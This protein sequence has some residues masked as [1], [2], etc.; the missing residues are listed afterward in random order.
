MS[1]QKFLASLQFTAAE[2]AS[3]VR[4]AFR[5]QPDFPCEQATQYVQLESRTLY[6]AAPIAIDVVD[7]A[8]AGED[9]AEQAV[10]VGLLEA[11]DNSAQESQPVDSATMEEQQ[12]R[13]EL[14]LVDTATNDYQ[15]LVDDILAQ[16][17]A[18][19]HIEV[20]L[21][22]SA[23]DGIEQIS[24]FLKNYQDL[25][26]I[27]LVSHGSDGAVKFGS[28]WLTSDS[29]AVYV[30]DI[31]GWR[32]ALSTD[33]DM[34][35]YGCDLASTVEGRTLVD[36]LAM[37]CDCDVAASNDATGHESLGGDWELE[38]SVGVID[39]DL[40]FESDL[41]QTWLAILAPG[42][43][44]TAIWR[45]SGTNTPEFNQWDG[46]SFGSEGSAAN[47]GEWRIMQGAEAPTRD[48]AIIVG[49]DTG[50][51]IEGQMWNG[52]SWS[53]LSI[54]PLGTVSQTYWWGMDV[55]YE[56]DSGDALMVWTDG[57]NVK[58]ATWNGTAWS[59]VNTLGIYTGA[60]PRQLQLAA[61]PNNDEM[62]LVVSD[63]NSRDTA[64]VW[65]GD[66]WGNSV[67]LATS[68]AGDRTDINVAYEQQSGHA[69]V[70]YSDNNNNDLR[71]Q[72]WNGVNWSGQNT[73]TDPGASND[74]R[75]T[76][77][78]SDPNSD[79]IAVGVVTF[80]AEAWF[81]VW[82]GSAWGD[83]ILAETTTNGSTSLNVA[84]AFE[85]NSGDVL[86]AYAEGTKDDMRYR[87]WSSGGGWSAELTTPDKFGDSLNAMT[88]SSDPFSDQIML[89]LQ[90]DG[91]DLNFV[92]WNGSA[93]ESPNEQ[94]TNTGETKNQP[95]LF[96]WD[97]QDVD[98]AVLT[99]VQDT[100][101]KL[102]ETGNNF[103]VGSQLIV[104]RESTDL[105][106]ALVQFDLSSIPV[107]AIIQSA[108]LNLEATAVDGI[109]TI[110]VYQLLESWAEGTSNGSS[111]DANW[112]NRDTGTA[113]TTAGGY[114][115]ATAID[116]LTASATGQHSW[117]ITT[118][119]QD[120]V[121]GTD[122]NY[123]VMIAS[124][125][126]GGNRT[127]SFDSREGTTAPQ[128]IIHYSVP[129]LAPTDITPNT[130]SVNEHVNTVGG[131][132]VA[133]LTTTDP[134]IG[135]TFTYTIIGGA[136]AAKFS[137]GGA[138]SDELLLIDGVL[139]FEV[140]STYSV[141]VRTT[142]AAGAWYE[143][144]L[145]VSV[146]DL[147]DAPVLDNAG[148]M[149]LGSV[150][151]NTVEPSGDLVSAIIAS[152]GG[153]RITDADSGAVEGMAVT[154]VDNAQGDWQYSTNGGSS[155]TSFGSVSNA[156]AVVLTDT[157]SD[158]IRFVPTLG[159]TGSATLSFRAWDTSDAN[160]SGTTGVDTTTNGG[161]TAYSA[162]TETAGIY[163]EPT[164]VLLW[165]STTGDVGPAYSQPDS[166]VAGLP[167]WSQSSVIGMGDPNLSFG[168]G[169]T[170]GTFGLVSNFDAFAADGATILN[171]LHYVTYDIVLTGAGISGGNI[172]LLAEDILLVAG[173]ADTLTTT[174]SGAPV[175]WSNSLAVTAGNVYAFRAENSGD[176]SSGYLRLLMST[177]GVDTTQAITL[178][179]QAVT[180]GGDVVVAAG[181]F[182]F[183]QS[184]ATRENN[185]YWYDTSTNTA[186]LLIDG[187]DVGIGSP[188]IVGLEL[189]EAAS[190]VG[191][192][193][194]STGDILVTVDRTGT[195]GGNNL[196]V[197]AQDVFTLS[198]T[199]TTYGSGTAA[200]NASL[201]FDGDGSA[202]FDDNAE[203]L[204]AISLI[205]R[206]TGTNQ[207]P[208]INN[209][210]GP[211]NF[212]ENGT[213]VIVDSTINVADADS[214]DFNGGTLSVS[215][216]AGVAFGDR[217]SIFNQGTG[218]GQIGVSG[219]NVTY[220]FG[221]GAITIGTFTGGFGSGSPLVVNLNANADST[222]T[223]A[224][225]RNVTFWNTSD[226]P[227]TAARTIEF[228]LTDGDGGTSS[229]ISQ[230]A[231]VTAQ[232]DAPVAVN[233]GSGLDFDG[234]DD[235]VSIADDPSL[236]MTSTMTMEAWINPD[237][238]ANGNRMIINKEGEYEVAL[239]SNDR[240]YWAFANS[241]PGW[242]WH[243]TGYTVT[244]GEWT[245]IAVTYDNG[246][247]TTY[248][249]GQAVDS[250]SGSGLIGDT[251]P[252]LNELRIGG[253]MNNPAG[254]FFDGRIDD[255]R[256]W[257]TVR[258]QG[259]IQSNLDAVLTGGEAGLAGH[260]SFSEGT[261]ST[262]TDSTASS[263]DGTLVD[264]G[265][266]TVGPQWTGY[267]TNEDTPLNIAVGLGIVANDLD[268]DGDSLL[269]TQINGSGANVG[270][271]FTLASGAQ[272]TVNA[273][274]DFSYDPNGAFEYLTSGQRVT[275]TFTYQISDGNGGFETA[276]VTI[277]ISG[278]ND[279]PTVGTNTGTT[280]L[281]GSGA[282][283]ITSALLNEG[284]P[285]DDG[286]ELTYTVTAVSIHG[287]LTLSGFGVLGLNDTFTQAD[288]DAGNLTYDHD[289]SESVSDAFNFS[290]ADGGE[291]G[292]SAA[293]GTFNI[294]ITAVNDEQ[295]LTTNTG[296][297]VAEGSTGNV[298]TAAMLDTNDVD[299]TDA[300]LVYTVDV[301]P[302]NGTLYRNA[303]ALSATDTFTQ[304][305]IVAGLISYDHDGSQTS[306]D[307]FDFTVDDGAGTTTSSTF[308]WTITN[309]NDAPV[310]ASI[311]GAALAYTEN[312]G[313]AAITS[314]L[315]ISDVDD[316]NI[317]SAVVQ[318]TGNYAN[319]QDVLT[320]V[321][322]NGITGTWTAGTGTLSL[323]GSAT[324]AQYEAALRS[325]TYTN[326]S[327]NPS[328]L[329]RTVSVTVNDGDV[330]SQ[331]LTREITIGNV[332]D[333]PTNAGSLP[334]D[335][336]VTE[337]VSSNV[338]LSAINLS[339]VDHS[340]G[341]LTVTLSTSAGGNL[342]AASGG[343]VTVGGSGTGTLTLTGTLASLNSYL[344]TASNVQYLHSTTHLNGNDADTINVVV[345][346][347]GNTGTGGGTNQNLGTVNVDITAV[348]DEQVLATNTGATVAEGST[349][350][351][352]TAAMLDTN[353][354][355]NTDAQLVYTV[356]VAPVNG[357]LYRNAVALSATD[358][359]SQA[360]IV[361]GLISYDH[362][363]SQ[364]SNDSFDFT[365]DDG[366]GTTTSSTFNWTV[367]NTND[368]PVQSSIE[369][370]ALAYTENDG[371]VAI[372]ST[373]AISDVDDTTLESA[374]VQITGNYANGQ[375]VLAF[376]NQ[377]GI[378]GTWTAGTGTLSLS[379][380]ATLAQY[381]AALRSITY[382]NTSENP[383][384]LT[385]TVSFTVNDGDVNSNTLT[386]DITLSSVNDD[387]TNAGSLP[388]DITVTEDVSSNVDLSA[389]N[390]SDVDHSGGNLTVTLNT[391]TGGNL[392]ASS[393][394]GVTVGGSGTGTLTLTGTLASLN[395]FLDTAS[396]V[397][398]L[399]STTHLNGNDAD[400]I[401]VVVNDNGNTGTGGGTNQNLGTVNVDITAVNDEQVLATNTGA[402]VAEGS[403]GNVV[404]AAMLDT[405]DVD[406][407]DAQL[408][409]TVDVAPVNGTLYRN[410]VALSATDTFT[411]A[412][413]VAG[414]IS[415]D[416]DGS[417][418]S[419]DSF[420]FTVDDGAG[421][422]TSAT[423]TWT[424]SNTND[425]P[426]QSSIEGAALAYT[427]NDGAVA[428]TST[429]AIS[430]VDDTNLE[431]AVVQITGNYANGQ[432]VLAFV[433]QNGIT[434]TWTAGTGTLSLSG[435][436]ALAQ[437][438]A[439]LRS[440][441]YT[442]TSDNPS[443]LTRT[444]SI[445]VN[446]GD[447]NSNTLTRDIALSS[448]NDD[449]T[450][451][452]SLPSDITVTED[453][454]SNVDLS[455]INLS[456]VDH[457]GGNLTVTLSTSTGGNL[458]A[459][460]G[461]GV[462]VGGSG[463]GT[464][465]LIGTLAS[466]NTF[467][468]TPAN[469]Q[470]LHG[471]AN[472]FGNDADT[473]NVVVND[474][475]NT[476]SGGGSDQ[477]LGT[478]NVDITAVNDEQVLTTN[479]GTT[480]AEGSTGNVITAAMLD[481]NDVDNTDAQLV[482]TVDVA[483]VNGTLYRNGVALSAT[484]TF[485]Q[486]DIVAGLITYDHDGSQTSSDSFDFTV[487]DGT[488][489]TTSST[490][491]WTISNTNDAPVQS[492]IEG[493]ALAYSENDG[494]V[495]I[496]STLAIS[497]VD[498]T[499]IESAVVQITG[500]YANGQDV[501]TF[502]DQNGITGTW[503]AG[504][505]TLSLSGSA[506]LAQYEAAL[507]SITYTNTSDNPSTLTRT[508]S[509]TVNDGDV[510]S[511]TLTRDITVSSVND[512][513]T[514]AGSLPSD[515]TVT[516]D[517]SSNVD[518]SAI[519][520]SDVDHSGG[521]LTVTLSTST[522]GNLSASSGGGV[523]VGGSGTGSLTLTGT[524]ASLNTF[525]DTASNVQ[526]L[527]STANLNGNDADTI[528]VVVNDNGNTGSGG[529]TNQ[530]LGTVNVDITA[531][532][533]EQV[534]TT[535]TGATV[536]EGSTGNVVTAAM[537]DTND[538][539]NTDAQLIY[540]VD[541]APVNGTLYRN[542]VALSA[543]DTLYPGRHRGR[544]DY[545]RPRRQ[546]D[547]QRQF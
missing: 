450:N 147:N 44:G 461:G 485:T 307:S 310:Q 511:N 91:S 424:I 111:D 271:Q 321:D 228:V 398:Y 386:R 89:A 315:A 496:T 514:N 279:V 242:A 85:S 219:N 163:V 360:D 314:T 395:T 493:A 480:V 188:A 31:V 355:D 422:T 332:N 66:A 113:W 172:N 8:D 369:G 368:A 305:D 331:H 526:Y 375:D 245:H 23:Q 438:E 458:S 237:A 378:T 309:V 293:T 349:G 522:G 544:A 367:S 21:L 513:P 139:D 328:T 319:G 412:D 356:D 286:S 208:V 158:K 9:L 51:T 252:V 129:N 97:Q 405:N 269:V 538:V 189:V 177:P 531:V 64:Y 313:A 78:A 483:P 258:T 517:V 209:S 344:D 108:T 505:G 264:G 17:S 132:S 317:E 265:A 67:T 251:Y 291:D 441:T 83:Q 411:Q 214:T 125:D 465:T 327:E 278:V 25:D 152:A 27:H 220:N 463:T 106:R 149:Q 297:T 419:S 512:D 240:I 137:I 179:E 10:A 30:S 176:Y 343:G 515:I 4:C 14:V 504:T 353:D 324:L 213:P 329:T 468:D 543:T 527:H 482:Y 540:T 335:I 154:A 190:T 525:L 408:V 35:I 82:D 232:P 88:L 509:F 143:E 261:G 489:T 52:T 101:I 181:D 80:N 68:T 267:V 443:T 500:N 192:V 164:E 402:T 373:L 276:A 249:N 503:T 374:V 365:V 436:A 488:G 256:I 301:A 404:T 341:N 201:L 425:A 363:G 45:E 48:E 140:K 196:S 403:T 308:S 545:L 156:S 316:T 174:A 478:V 57:A 306:N 506:T 536:A 281:E 501:L 53:S 86:A 183:A 7:A 533:D 133:T 60:T 246:T 32:D 247:V 477:N 255:V 263:N 330:D 184:G 11:E 481:T 195:V 454:S 372:T 304:A 312:D 194:L 56:S 295:V 135:D 168:S 235:Y 69:L 198:A 40:P 159:F 146:N 250:Y 456:D 29:I 47:V 389:I 39:A 95:F 471:T 358:T 300:Q 222:A 99:A 81:A 105:Q 59:S 210:G 257:N 126:G 266:G 19:R 233:D 447:V 169:T 498:D 542:A 435:S 487:D 352:V 231:T 288:L 84:V 453:V 16:Q 417:Q 437:Y 234:I 325:I 484:D 473:I 516:E 420:D 193:A 3:L 476:G 337:D 157:A 12:E 442:N 466:L 294:T 322:Q 70:V 117:D 524:L 510:N 547:Q 54:N 186:H 311:E 499:N 537:L 15:Q 167:S 171:G 446:D 217:L 74:V 350:N 191:G 20:Q 61:S 270:S 418:T 451:A 155:W 26:A 338:D 385:R 253:R 546:P 212:V 6:S 260:W 440:I 518:L 236:V 259:E 65:D 354:V 204:D 98:T 229:T 459:S 384:T 371:A 185:I 391:S 475:G 205:L 361:A 226:N 460:S 303:V 46:L 145:A 41:R 470:Y 124:P 272:L 151:Q 364:T 170:T 131:Y 227:A 400:T 479:T 396:N 494:A 497:D 474:N 362:D 388:S 284:D 492:L 100:Y 223:Q 290:L 87:T 427:E 320:F 28:T 148:N 397:Q 94:E 523:T 37:V 377:N 530:N 348:N 224:L 43:S 144:T 274:G 197:T 76:T 521:N 407:T 502:V 421:T 410:A 414:L 243:D 430:D 238:S 1:F 431:S 298:V 340:G 416:H 254:K 71:Y 292:A 472:T 326:T 118:L 248:V 287:T 520:L 178:V 121:D 449:P 469:V 33:A 123:G 273:A 366:A 428:L 104:D 110:D 136:D 339:D 519:N 318:I 115:D 161:A 342:S 432:D 142:D 187:D 18:G 216:S 490:F 413:L 275:D 116:S 495:A 507:R 134:D 206:G 211:V 160:P 73:L 262:T 415:Y 282:N 359:F 393:G 457:S 394:G 162:A 434:G 382:T 347:L 409:Y 175:G 401:N 528:N 392:S 221:A 455:A 122:A 336:T 491:T 202:S 444:V 433:D 323:S 357:T 199:A 239:F 138:G 107:D 289:G 429:L 448:V 150:L 302:V 34:L 334:T 5:E 462:T 203:S 390:L 285:D 58:Y 230:A 532:N 75:W 119:V 96:L 141:T 38:Y 351:V 42:N 120:W 426:V 445:T 50:G 381:E 207:A 539:D 346:D 225:M 406:N 130:A 529:G 165:M 508:V 333:D 79:R 112:T 283:T 452:G 370:T 200:A 72:I 153:N 180:I 63:S 109:L 241:D 77:I 166:G 296:T 399:H 439:A 541:V 277:T 2:W 379:G 62:V 387:P 93:W 383:S 218:I 376:T 36:M 182:L 128:L 102:G 467:L 464:L 114:F 24:N 90:D 55:A 280:V 173:S 486:A 299:N 345:N 49:V 423:F 22:D 244:N 103:G 215:I 535:N 13:N 534:L 268:I 127:F 380:S 92:I